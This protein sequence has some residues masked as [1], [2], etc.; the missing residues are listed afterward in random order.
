M[1]NIQVGYP[2]EDEEFQIVRLTTMSREV[3]LKHV[4]SG[5]DVL[6]LQEIVR[7]CRWRSCDSLC[8]AVQPTDAKDGRGMSGFHQGICGLGR[9]R[10]RASI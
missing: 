10:G 1:F 2:T 9:G 8:A 3:D 7:K 4:L 6:Q 5:E